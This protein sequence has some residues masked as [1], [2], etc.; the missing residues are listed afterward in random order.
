MFGIG[1]FHNLSKQS[2]LQFI[3]GRTDNE[4]NATYGQAAAPNFGQPGSDHQVFHA[5][6]KH[7]F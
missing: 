7:T 4:D 1:Y 3:Y 5:G 6:I 2:Q